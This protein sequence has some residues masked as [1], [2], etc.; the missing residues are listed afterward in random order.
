MFDNV[1]INLLTFFLG[2]LLGHRLTLGRDRRKEFNDLSRENYRSLCNQIQSRKIEK[3]PIDV[4]VLSHYFWPINRY[5]FVKAARKYKD[6]RHDSGTYDPVTD[7]NIP[8][9]KSTAELIK[10]ASAV[11]KF[12]IPR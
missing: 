3:T 2:L 6:T 11:S 12:L 1:V 7:I 9:E 5:R 4:A 8:N 10:N